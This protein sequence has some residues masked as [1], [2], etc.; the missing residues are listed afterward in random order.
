[1]P[2]PHGDCEPS[3]DYVQTKCLSQCEANYVI[4][5]CSCKLVHM[6]GEITQ[7]GKYHC[8]LVQTIF[9]FCAVGALQC[10]QVGHGSS[11]I[12]VRWY[13]MHLAPPIVGLYVR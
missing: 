6:P 4:D 7:I 10:G 5:N 2:N 1:M 3:S 9:T 12:L 8:L 11:K 13:T